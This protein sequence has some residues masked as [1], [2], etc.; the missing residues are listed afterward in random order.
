MVEFCETIGKPISPES[1]VLP[2]ARALTEYIKRYPA[3][4]RLVEATSGEISGVKF[5]AVYLDIENEVPQRRTVDIREIERIGVQFFET[6]NWYPEVSALRKDFPNIPH[7]NLRNHAI[8]KSI[9][10]YEQDWAQVNL[11]WT[12]ADF[13]NRLKFWFTKSSTGDLHAPDQPLEPFL[14]SASARI[15]IDQSILESQQE[16]ASPIHIGG[17]NFE[18]K[19]TLKAVSD[20]KILDWFDYKH[21][22]GFALQIT[23]EPVTHGI[24]NRAPKTLA[25]LDRLLGSA[26]VSLLA[27]LREKLKSWNNQG[28][29][30]KNADA[31]LALFVAVPL[32]RADSS[33]TETTHRWAF[34]MNAKLR[35]LGQKIGLWE[36][37]SGN[38][39]LLLQLD[40][41]KNGDDVALDLLNISYDFS[42]QTAAMMNGKDASFD[43][44]ITVVGLG[45]LGSKMFDDLVRM[46]YSNFALIDSDILLPHN[47]SRHALV[48]SAVGY[49][50][51]TA[52]ANLATLLH[53]DKVNV[54]PYFDDLLHPVRSAEKITDELKSSAIILDASATESVPRYLGRDVQTDSP[55]ISVFLSPSGSDLIFLKE[56]K[57]RATKIDSIEFQY[58][59][60]LYRTEGLHDLLVRPE[61]D[62]R[63]AG[64]CRDITSRL[65]TSNISI[66]SGVASSA[67]DQFFSAPEGRISIWRL[68]D[69]YEIKKFE[70][71]VSKTTTHL[72]GDWSVLIDDHVIREI[73]ETREKRLPNETGGILLGNFDTKRKIIYVCD[74]LSAPPDSEEGSQSFVRGKQGLVESMQDI[75]A[76][77]MDRVRYVGEWHSHPKG[78]SS[79]QSGQDILALAELTRVMRSD[80]LPFVMF[81][82]GDSDH[83]V[84]LGE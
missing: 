6:D 84:S 58:Y 29:V 45:A 22:K 38:I 69:N 17:I 27:T 19:I 9:C 7:L 62:V 16:A 78:S 11:T 40:E 49:G 35:D 14:P 31:M 56:D 67:I 13:I 68:S 44:R 82:F 34:L 4:L 79:A 83:S 15:V 1:F 73:R 3:Y 12:P 81:I 32:K 5:E 59:R 30:Q 39:G 70:T 57:A 65:P 75:S 72:L 43:H 46:G 2:K 61:S 41:A 77:T 26:G 64:S 33:H 48:A 10:L 51:T 23:T 53:T 54:R 36:V 50:K 74:F 66:L 28:I 24:I 37:R 76:K 18:G 20:P 71:S 80:A 47:L 42:P 63:Y 52:L 60:F 8:P 55:V 21:L 25:D